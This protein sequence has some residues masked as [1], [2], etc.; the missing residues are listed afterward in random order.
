[1]KIKKFIRWKVIGIVI[2]LPV[3]I[4]SG[5]QDNKPP[6]YKEIYEA[7]SLGN[8]QDVKRH[9][10]NGTDVKAK[11]ELGGFTALHWA[12]YGGHTDVV[13]L[14][15][16]NGADVNAKNDSGFTPLHW[17]AT[18]DN[19]AAAELLISKGADVNAKDIDGKTPLNRAEE[20][21]KSE[22]VELLKKHGASK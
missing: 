15:I 20:Q 1:M 17:A 6:V 9:L 22:M 4:C 2:L 8:V 3:F 13:E 11:Q 19:K 12:A 7:A 16:A 10:K 5:C 18:W 21:G 14:L